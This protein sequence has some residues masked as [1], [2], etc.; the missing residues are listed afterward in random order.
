MNKIE[1]HLTHL[2]EFY[3]KGSEKIDWDD[4]SNFERSYKL[5]FKLKEVKARLAYLHNW[6]LNIGK[7]VYLSR[8]KWNYT[9]VDSFS[10][11]DHHN[12]STFDNSYPIIFTED[13]F[14]R[15]CLDYIS[16]SIDFLLRDFLERSIT[17]NSTWKLGNLIFEWELE[18]KQELLKEFKSAI[19]G[20]KN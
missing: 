11:L 19:S 15:L 17:S 20:V 10:Q 9:L 4:L 16:Y 2:E 3:N 7:E 12:K 1:Q 8:E 5:N 18:C 6:R 14:D 13:D